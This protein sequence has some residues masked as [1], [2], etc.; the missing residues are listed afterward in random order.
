MAKSFIRGR[1]IW[2]DYTV[3]GVRFKKSS[4][5]NNTQKN[6][7]YV[8]D[9]IIPQLIKDIESGAIYKSKPD[10][11]KYYYGIFIKSKEFNRSLDKKMLYYRKIK[12]HFG[13]RKITSITR[14]DIK[15]YLFSLNIKSGSKN[16][17]KSALREIFELAVDDEIIS[18]N[19]A[20]N[21]KLPPDE[22]KDIEYFSIDEVNLLLSKAEGV[23]YLYLLIAFNTGLRP[24]EILALQIGDFTD[25]HINVRRSISRGVLGEPKTKNSYRKVPYPQFILDEVK[26]YH[27]NTIFIFDK[28]YDDSMTLRYMWSNLLNSC[29]LP[30]KKLYSTRHTYATLMLQK[31]I[32]SINELAG[33]LGHSSPKVTLA[34]YASIIDS[35]TIDLGKNFSLYGTVQNSVSIG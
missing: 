3:D 6:L 32:M 5:L 33:V 11:F 10:T 28:K 8:N 13:D 1:K 23:I 29:K 9:K 25:K 31:N 2:I 14:L 19:P 22:K 4:K 12:A 18:I 35:S 24:E 20:V 17:Y 16:V 7:Q 15:N 26:K 34:H 27:S 21:I 30:H